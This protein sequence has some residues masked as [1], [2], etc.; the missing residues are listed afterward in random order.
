MKHYKLYTHQKHNHKLSKVASHNVSMHVKWHAQLHAGI[1]PN[2]AKRAK[3]FGQTLEVKGQN[4][5]KIISRTFLSPR[6]GYLIIHKP[7][8]IS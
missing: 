4:R 8:L 1:K 3:Q 7:R 5:P 6:K 2:S